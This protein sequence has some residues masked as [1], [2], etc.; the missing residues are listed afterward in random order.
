MLR[1]P[2]SSCGFGALL[3]GT[4]VVILRVERALAIHPPPPKKITAGPRLKLLTFG[5]RVR[6]STIK[7]RLPPLVVPAPSSNLTQ[8]KIKQF[9]Y[10]THD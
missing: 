5:L 2:G 9:Y 3:K 4:S 8:K 10:E 7:P 6:L 1:R